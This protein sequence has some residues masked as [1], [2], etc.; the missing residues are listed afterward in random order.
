MQYSRVQAPNSQHHQWIALNG[1]TNR[2][3]HVFIYTDHRDVQFAYSDLL[4][5]NRMPAPWETDPVDEPG[6][7]AVGGV[8]TDG[9][10]D[11]IFR[12]C[13]AAESILLNGLPNIRD[14]IRATPVGLT[15]GFALSC[16]DKSF[17]IRRPLLHY[18]SAGK[19]ANT[20]P[21]VSS[22]APARQSPVGATPA[23]TA[24]APRAASILCHRGAPH[25]PNA[26]SA[27]AVM[28]F[29]A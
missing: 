19:G 16:A 9:T 5:G 12:R 24:P 17:L 14:L 11:V 1:Q 20:C 28:H 8:N 25:T 2:S 10:M 18:A 6:E 21:R 26:N 13:N 3:A 23:A 7:K 27:Q 4:T 15:A 29:T 22:T